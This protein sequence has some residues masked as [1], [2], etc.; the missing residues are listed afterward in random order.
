M[1]VNTSIGE[2]SISGY[3]YS[4]GPSDLWTYLSSHNTTPVN[5]TYY[6][7]HTHPIANDSLLT[8]FVTVTRPNN[9]ASVDT[10]FVPLKGIPSVS[11]IKDTAV[12][13]GL[14]LD[15]SFT[16]DTNTSPSVTTTFEWTVSN[17]STAGFPPS[18]TTDHIDVQELTNPTA[19]PVTATITVTPKK[20][21]CDGVSKSFKVTVLPQSLYNYP[22][23]RIRVC[24]EGTGD[25]NLSKYIDTLDVTSLTWSLPVDNNGRMARS[26]ISKSNVST[27]TYTISNHCV[28]DLRRKIYV[29][30]L[31]SNRMR[32]LRDTILI[33]Y[34]KAGMLQI[35]QIFGIDAGGEWEYYALESDNT[36]VNIDAYVT[37]SQSSTY[38]G[39]VVM[40][41]KAIYEDTEINWCPYRGR[42]DTK[43][44]V[45]I[46]TAK[47]EC[48]KNQSFKIVIILTPQL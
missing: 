30:R 24:P 42:S 38:N 2:Q 18:G 39:A 3:T 27:I 10:V 33:C 35:N 37:E 22:D 28:V 40:D 34:D 13:H 31:K 15:I 11:N 25:I 6:D 47:D 17:G 46:Y 36:H 32:P 8:Y 41:G 20:N 4:W 14:P 29:E 44:V 48:L 16:D 9:C 1:A 7:Y 43:Q 19:S 21:G 23:L 5:F 12:C 45:F 26:C